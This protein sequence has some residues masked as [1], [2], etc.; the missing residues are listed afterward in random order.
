MPTVELQ[1]AG[2]EVP[3]SVSLEKTG[4]SSYAI[5]VDQAEYTVMLQWESPHGGWVR[6][7]ETGEVLPFYLL[8]EEEQ[9]QLWLAGRTYRFNRIS[10]QARRQ[11]AKGAGALLGAGEI[12]APM[13]GTVLKIMVEPGQSVEANAPLLIMESMK[14]EMTLSA[15]AK[16]WVADILCEV[17]QLVEMNAVLVKLEAIKDEPVS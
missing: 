5:Q 14:M 17:G 9:V 3:V 8:M 4:E 15:P 11:Q 12:K 1:P 6:N 10:P 13:P 16:A 2:Q 7:M